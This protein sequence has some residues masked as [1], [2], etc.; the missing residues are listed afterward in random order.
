M[1]EE[2]CSGLAAEATPPRE[3]AQDGRCS[4]ALLA[5]FERQRVEHRQHVV[6][7]DLVGP[8]ED[9]PRITEAMDH[10]GVDVLGARKPL[11]EGERR[12]VDD[13]AN[14]PAEDEPRRVVDPQRVFAE[15]LEEVLSGLGGGV[16]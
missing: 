12:L 10:P 14:D 9:A 5:S 7:A 15:C 3:A 11:A 1:L 13:L 4:V 16:G 2:P 6:E 8:G